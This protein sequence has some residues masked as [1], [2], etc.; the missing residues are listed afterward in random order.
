M[1]LFFLIILSFP[2]SIHLNAQIP[3]T[4][5]YT[6]NYC[7]E[8]YQKCL[9]KCKVVIKSNKI[10]VYAPPDL[11]LIKEGEL[12]DSGTL[13]KAPSGKWLILQSKEDRDKVKN[14]HRSKPNWVDFKTKRFWTF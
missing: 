6:Y 14:K 4:G 3:K 1:K 2:L 7:D 8:E 11:T 10:W 9:G 13:I 5:T 12:F